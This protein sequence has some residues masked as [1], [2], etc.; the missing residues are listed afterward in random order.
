[1]KKAVNFVLVLSNSPSTLRLVFM[2]RGGRQ[3]K[4]D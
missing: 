3:I 2:E 4:I 1:M